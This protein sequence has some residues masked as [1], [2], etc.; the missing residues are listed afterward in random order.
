MEALQHS[1]VL[2]QAHAS[3]EIS[4]TKHIPFPLSTD[5][6]GKEIIELSP[7][8]YRGGGTVKVP[9]PVLQGIKGVSELFIKEVTTM[10]SS[11]TPSSIQSL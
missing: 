9:H 11:H 10:K 8:Y 4:E 3:S 7:L 6:Q 2:I 5:H 1:A